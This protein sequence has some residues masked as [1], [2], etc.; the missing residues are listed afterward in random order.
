MLFITGASGYLGSRLVSDL[1]ARGHRI[2]ALVRPGSASR[3]AAPGVDVVTGDPLRADSFARHVEGCRTLI[4][5]V[6]TPKPAPWKTASFLAVDRPSALASFS[7]AHAAGVRHIVYVSV[8]QPAPVMKSYIAVRKY[9]EDVLAASGTPATVL[10]PWYV[11]GPGHW[12]PYALLPFYALG[13]SLAATRESARRLGLL[14]LDEM[15]LALRW[16]AEN[17]AEGWRVL[18]V[19]QIRRIA[20]SYGLQLGR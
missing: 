20:S 16:A 2:R 17:P 19:G 18:D 11:L 8:A 15:I 10:R 9:C 7:A 12:W 3:I 4:H 1:A 13:E 5:L 6:G 14:R